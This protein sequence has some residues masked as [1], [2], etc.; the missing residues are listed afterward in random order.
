MPKISQLDKLVKIF[1]PQ[2]TKDGYG[3]Y[4]VAWGFAFHAW[5]CFIPI[6]PGPTARG[7]RKPKAWKYKMIIR[8][9]QRL[10]SQMAILYRKQFYSI[11]HLT[12]HP[13]DENF[14]ELYL[15]EKNKNASNP[16]N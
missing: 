15:M 16:T 4:E 8:Y 9:D 11:E 7:L 14:T 1:T 2:K 3:G 12:T 6:T 13:E 5:A 10:S